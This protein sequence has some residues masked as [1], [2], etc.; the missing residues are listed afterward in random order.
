MVESG[1]EGVRRAF[2]AGMRHRTRPAPGCGGK[3][4]GKPSSTTQQCGRHQ[5]QRVRRCHGR[6][7]AGGWVGADRGVAG[8]LVLKRLRRDDRHLLAHALVGL[9]VHRQPRI[10]PGEDTMG[11]AGVSGAGGWRSEG[12]QSSGR[13]VREGAHFSMITRAARLTVF[14]RTP[15]QSA[16]CKTVGERRSAWR[17]ACRERRARGQQDAT[18]ASRPG[19]LARTAGISRAGTLWHE[20]QAAAYHL[21]TTL[22]KTRGSWIALI[23]QP[24]IFVKKCFVSAPV[25]GVVRASPSVTRWRRPLRRRDDTERRE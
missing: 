20:A 2:G 8:D 12:M 18:C 24:D 3:G 21:A 10:V 1:G 13:A 22:E 9:E 16:K 15:C 23:R 14:V 6:G 11:C 4:G 17:A 5:S 19:L 7:R 25:V